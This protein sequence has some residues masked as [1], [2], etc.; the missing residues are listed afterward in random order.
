MI[1]PEIISQ[2]KI[3]EMGKTQ[4]QQGICVFTLLLTSAW[5]VSKKKNNAE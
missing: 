2:R 1:K 4:F 5:K 3:V